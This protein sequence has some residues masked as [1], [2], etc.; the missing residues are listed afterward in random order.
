MDRKSL[1]EQVEL[2]ALHVAEHEALIVR[3][4]ALVAQLESFGQ[5]ASGAQQM[6]DQQ[7]DLLRRDQA[8]LDS[9]RMQLE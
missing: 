2:A 3:M 7:R 5:D 9:L 4:E 1:E 6:L 8:S